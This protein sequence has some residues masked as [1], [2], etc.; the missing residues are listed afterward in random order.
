MQ[1]APIDVWNAQTFDKGLMGM[2]S[3]ESQLVR[4]YMT[5][6]I[7]IVLA[8]DHGRDRKGILRPENPHAE[9][10]LALKEAVTKQLGTRTIRAWHYTRLTDTEVATIRSDGVHLST[11]AT[12][13]ARLD[14]RVAAAE[15]TQRVAD[16]LYKA[17]PFRGDQRTAR[18]GKFWM[19]SHPTAV[20]NSGVV[21]LMAR[22]GGEVASFWTKEAALV[23][24]LTVL[25]TP[26][27]IELAVPLALT[28]HAYSAACAI[29]AT[30]GRTLGCIPD[31]HGFDLYAKGPLGAD[32]VLSVHSMGDATFQAIGRTY[33]VGYIDRA[34][35]RWKELTGEED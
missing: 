16:A 12:L 18:S 34:I 2:L 20:D 10:F 14:G 28:S 31:K 26:R 19:V 7:E 17:S 32:A 21:P 35:G 9:Q 23:G 33:P 13:R 11:P 30:F 29:V 6:E 8:H 27:V 25:G 5:K 24:P 22:W 3:A 4:D 1:P 15:L